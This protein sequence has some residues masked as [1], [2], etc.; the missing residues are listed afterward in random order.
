MNYRP[1][2]EL[3]E[4]HDDARCPRDCPLCGRI[5]ADEYEPRSGRDHL[6]TRDFPEER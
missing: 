2:A 4:L 1:S 3:R 6:I 5:D